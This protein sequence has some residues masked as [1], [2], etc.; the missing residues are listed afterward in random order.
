MKGIAHGFIYFCSCLIALALFLM[1]NVGMVSLGIYDIEW[2][3]NELNNG[4]DTISFSFGWYILFPV[5]WM[6]SVIT[7]IIT[8]RIENGIEKEN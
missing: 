5:L 6:G 2:I 8:R 7:V 4:N 3:G 1:M